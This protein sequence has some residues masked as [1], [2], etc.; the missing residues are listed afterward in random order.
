[1]S[2][3]EKIKKIYPS[4]KDSDFGLNG[5]ISLRCDSDGRGEYIERWEHET[6]KKPTDE[7]LQQAA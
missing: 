7:Q 3:Y 5:S 4:I 2:L 1:M 6:F